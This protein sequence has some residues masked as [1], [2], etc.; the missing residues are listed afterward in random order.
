MPLGGSDMPLGESDMP[1]E[2]DSRE[3]GRGVSSG[4]DVG[5]AYNTPLLAPTTTRGGGGRPP[6]PQSPNQAAE[7]A[8]HRHRHRQRTTCHGQGG[9]IQPAPEPVGGRRLSARGEA[10]RRSAPEWR[11]RT[12][13]P[14][15]G[16]ARWGWGQPP[17]ARPRARRGWRHVP[18]RDTPASSC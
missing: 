18:T 17:G 5:V 6:D 3:R 15:P 8:T 12:A 1:L 7:H 4:A 10:Q 9:H 14:R 11:H 16:P 2:E 13:W